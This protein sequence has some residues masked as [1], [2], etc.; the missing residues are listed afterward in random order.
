MLRYGLV[1][2]VG[3]GRYVGRDERG[4]TS[5]RRRSRYAQKARPGVE[6]RRVRVAQY[7]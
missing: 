4:R 5:T 2:R 3:R 7:I 1:Q 6:T